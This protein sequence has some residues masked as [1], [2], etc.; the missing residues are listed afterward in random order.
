VQ[1]EA[2]DTLNFVADTS[3][4]ENVLYV[5]HCEGYVI[6][7]RRAALFEQGATA[8]GLH[9]IANRV[10]ADRKGNLVY[11]LFQLAKD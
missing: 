8:A 7:P 10:V 4:R 1:I 5:T 6:D 11:C 9:Q 3:P 2:G